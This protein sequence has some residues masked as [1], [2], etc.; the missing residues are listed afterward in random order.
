MLKQLLPRRQ[1]Q[2]P[3]STH[4]P[5]DG[6]NS[7]RLMSQARSKRLRGRHSG[8][9]KPRPVEMHTAKTGCA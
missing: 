6:E 2:A 9:V 1:R 3:T 8:C 7:A 4:H 5:E